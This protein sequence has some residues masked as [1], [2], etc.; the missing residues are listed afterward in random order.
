VVRRKGEGARAPIDLW[1]EGVEPRTAEHDI[2]VAD[3]GR[4]RQER[5]YAVGGAKGGSDR[6]GDR[7]RRRR[8]VVDK[9]QCNRLPQE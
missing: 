9:S 7:A 2:V 3:V 1:V 8:R 6:V 5:R 4:S